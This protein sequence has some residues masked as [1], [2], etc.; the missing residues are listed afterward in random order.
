MVE[1]KSLAVQRDW[2]GGNGVN[3]ERWHQVDDLLSA[4][5]EREAGERAS[6]LATAC[7]EDAELKRQVELLLRAHQRA[8]NFLEPADVKASGSAS[9]LHHHIGECE[10]C[11]HVLDGL[12][13]S[14]MK[15]AGAPAPDGPGE[16]SLQRG[17]TLG[18]YVVLDRL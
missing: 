18:R 8:G 13:D 10:D 15:L 5:L 14:L 9:E 16:V 6:F 1:N 12:D 7:R 17:A 4:V 3:P 11:R 2:T